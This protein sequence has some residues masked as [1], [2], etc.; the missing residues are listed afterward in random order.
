MPLQAE[1]RF[2]LG[3]AAL[4]MQVP[5]TVLWALRLLEEHAWLHTSLQACERLT[6]HLLGE[7]EP[8]REHAILP[9]L[10]TGLDPKPWDHAVQAVHDLQLPSL[11]LPEEAAICWCMPIS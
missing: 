2:L 7:F 1:K 4:L 3:A 5:L 11:P 6:I 10:D 9:G 8:D